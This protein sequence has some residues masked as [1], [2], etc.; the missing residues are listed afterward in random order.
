M[1]DLIERQ[2]KAF[3]VI[4][5]LIEQGLDDGTM[6]YLRKAREHLRL[7]MTKVLEALWPGTPVTEK[8][9]RLGVTRQ[10]Y[11]GWMSG[12]YRPDAK[13]ARKLS[14]LTGF[15]EDDIRGRLHRD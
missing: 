1:E 14:Q 11:Y 8:V 13:M 5:R 15:D 10:A 3:K 12:I 2:E 7:P 6:S 4:D 9:K